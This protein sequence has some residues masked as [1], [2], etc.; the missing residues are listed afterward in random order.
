MKNKRTMRIQKVYLVKDLKTL[1]LEEVI[2][3]Q[4]IERYLD[5]SNYDVLIERKTVVSA[6]NR[7]NKKNIILTER[8]YEYNLESCSLVELIK[9]YEDSRSE[10]SVYI[11]RKR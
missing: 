7:S 1:D 9:M 11:S 4:V 3:Y 5:G 8:V 10:I 2:P 6:S